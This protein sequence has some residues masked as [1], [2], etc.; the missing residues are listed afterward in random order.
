MVLVQ[1]NHYDFFS[2]ECWE[3][4]WEAALAEGGKMQGNVPKP[5]APMAAL[6]CPAARRDF[7]WV[8][9]VHKLQQPRQ[10]HGRSGIATQVYT[11]KI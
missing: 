11:L 1:M 6:A 5:H 9:L 2:Q 10:S 8:V 4:C 3:R 7:P